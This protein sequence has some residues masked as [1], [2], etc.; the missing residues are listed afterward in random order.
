[1]FKIKQLI[2]FSNALDSEEYINTFSH[3]RS[4][5][6]RYD[7]LDDKFQ[8]KQAED[9]CSLHNSLK[10]YTVIGRL[11]YNETMTRFLF[12]L[13]VDDATTKE[14]FDVIIDDRYPICIDR[15]NRLDTSEKRLVLLSL[16]KKLMAIALNDI[17][18]YQPGSVYLYGVDGFCFEKSILKH[19]ILTN[20]AINLNTKFR[21]NHHVTVDIENYY[22]KIINS[23]FDKIFSFKNEESPIYQL[24]KRMVFH[25]EEHSELREK[26]PEI[27]SRRFSD[28]GTIRFRMVEQS[29]DPRN[30][31]RSKS[32][33]GKDLIPVYYIPS[34]KMS[35]F[36]HINRDRKMDLYIDLIVYFI[37]NDFNVEK[38]HFFA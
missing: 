11:D 27:I 13:R 20:K 1:M 31:N 38:T 14:N 35:R 2:P 19:N 10:N 15:M 26:L 22:D 18:L 6:N 8:R 36:K 7:F 21:K 29:F 12:T 28:T 3:N 32:I 4:S 17:R 23:L 9:E 34:L 37:N 25:N 24:S 30:D 16:Y 33:S 5:L